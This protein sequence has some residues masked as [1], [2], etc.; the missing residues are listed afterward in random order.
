MYCRNDERAIKTFIEIFRVLF[1][2]GVRQNAHIPSA[3]VAAARSVVGVVELPLENGFFW[4][5]QTVAHG[6]VLRQIFMRRQSE[7]ILD[8]CLWWS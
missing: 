7:P 1:K 2:S 4:K 5:P 8:W 3:H 6:G